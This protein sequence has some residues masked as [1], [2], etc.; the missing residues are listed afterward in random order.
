[1]PHSREVMSRAEA[2][3]GRLVAAMENMRDAFDVAP[4]DRQR[5]IL[6]VMIAITGLID[7]AGFRPVPAGASACLNKCA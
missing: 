7:S 4:Q 3:F 2:E 1:M 5:G 6:D